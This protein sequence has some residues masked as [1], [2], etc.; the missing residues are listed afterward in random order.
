MKRDTVGKLSAELLKKEPETTDPI[1][2]MR[3]SLTEYD[4]NL[5]E[6]AALDYHRYPHNYFLVVLTKKERLMPN[7]L[8]NYFFTRSTCPTPEYDQTV[9][10]VNKKTD[11]IEFLWVV[12]SKDTCQYL[13]F[14]ALDVAKDERDLLH[15][16]M[17][18]YN[19][20][21]YS[22]AKQF[23]GEAVDS[24]LIIS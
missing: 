24:N 16:V 23:N 10:R 14:H 7:V 5:F 19:G 2:Q 17:Q 6:R 13:K 1:E 15:F 4:K 3:E 12:P 22:L 11:N 20:E 8:R 21:L 9:Y 18:F